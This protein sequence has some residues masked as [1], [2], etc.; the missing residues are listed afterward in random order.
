[1]SRNIQE[2]H[3]FFCTLH[4]GKLTFCTQKWWFGRWVPGFQ[5]GG[6]FGSSR[7]SSGVFASGSH[8]PNGG[9]VHLHQAHHCWLKPCE[10]HSGRCRFAGFRFPSSPGWANETRAQTVGTQGIYGYF[11]KWWVFPPNHPFL[12]GCFI[13]NHPFWG[14]TIFGNT[15][16]C[17]EILF[18]PGGVPPMQRLCVLWLWILRS[19]GTGW[20][21]AILGGWAP[22]CK[23]LGSPPF[24]SHGV[25]PFGKGPTTRPLG[26]NNDHHGY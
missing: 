19:Y 23:W 7:S 17:Y 9:Q 6:F 2:N 15:H 22:R 18:E 3:F 14:T 20:H 11:L 13:I 25:R 21:Q 1:M 12:I 4:P 8:H 24:I 26:D 5:L 16:I 10:A